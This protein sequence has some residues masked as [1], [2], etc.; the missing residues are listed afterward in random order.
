MVLFRRAAICGATNR[1]VEKGPNNDTKM[2]C[3]IT[4]AFSGERFEE[5]LCLSLQ[6]ERRKN[7]TVL[8]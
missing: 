1:V 3:V 2:T 5:L 6:G 4:K 7:V 8:T